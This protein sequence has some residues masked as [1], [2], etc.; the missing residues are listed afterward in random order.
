MS[1]GSYGAS[2]V[3]R[4]E[5]QGSYVTY[6]KRFFSASARRRD[7]KTGV[8]MPGG[9]FPI[10]KPEDVHNAMAL[11]H[12][13]DTPAVRAHIRSRAKALGMGDPFS[14]DLGSS[15]TSDIANPDSNTI[16]DNAPNGPLKEGDDEANAGPSRARM[17]P[18]IVKARRLFK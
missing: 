12:H 11:L 10:S 15:L 6:V 16:N 2:V 14:K 8:A 1:A 18:D 9:G 3:A 7:A 4:L 17:G 5:K 13:H